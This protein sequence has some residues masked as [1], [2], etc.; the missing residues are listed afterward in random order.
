M[1]AR[2]PPGKCKFILKRR[3]YPGVHSVEDGDPSS[4]AFKLVMGDN[5]HMVRGRGRGRGLRRRG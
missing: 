4:I 2:A 1:R 3:L 5:V